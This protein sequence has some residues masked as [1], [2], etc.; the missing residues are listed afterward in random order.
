MTIAPRP[1]REASQPTTNSAGAL[2]PSIVNV[3]TA[4]RTA[5]GRRRSAAGAGG[6]SGGAGRRAEPRLRA[7]ADVCVRR[8]QRSGSGVPGRG[9]TDG[10]RGRAARADAWLDPGAA[11]RG[12]V[13]AAGLV[14]AGRERLDGRRGGDVTA[15]E[16][17]AAPGAQ[18]PVEADEAASSW[19]RRG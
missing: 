5:G 10:G 14:Q 3:A 13:E 7:G 8:D 4:G 16:V 2:R 17:L 15:L 11:A 18:R 6:T 1:S 19:G 12:A 9:A